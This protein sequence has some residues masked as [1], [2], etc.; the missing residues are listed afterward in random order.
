MGECSHIAGMSSYVVIKTINGRQYR[1]RQET[2]R[3]GGR[4]RTRSKYLGAVEGADTSRE[5]DASVGSGV[6]AA[7]GQGTER[8][9]VPR[10]RRKAGVTEFLRDLVRVKERADDI[11]EAEVEMRERVAREEQAYARNDRVTE[12]LSG[13]T[14]SLDAIN[15]IADKNRGALRMPPHPTGV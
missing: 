4:M 1:Y 5:S 15:E 11:G 9:Y 3:E 12:L 14:I 2:W 13:D 7:L 6:P 8:A 10:R